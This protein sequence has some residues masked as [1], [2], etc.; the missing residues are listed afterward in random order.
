MT[1]SVMLL[2]EKL[3]IVLCKVLKTEGEVPL[4]LRRPERVLDSF[5]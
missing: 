3:H 5:N 1:R 2:V 4:K